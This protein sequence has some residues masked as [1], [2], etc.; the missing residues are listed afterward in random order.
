MFNHTLARSVGRCS[1]WTW[2]QSGTAA[3]AI[4]CKHF[5]PS[6][7]TALALQ[8]KGTCLATIA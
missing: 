3:S 1:A 8:M 4:S 2:E 5:I 6:P 7:V